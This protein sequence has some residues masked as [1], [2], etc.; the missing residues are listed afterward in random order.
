MVIAFWKSTLQLKAITFCG[1]IRCVHSNSHTHYVTY[2]ICWPYVS[3]HYI[4][5]KYSSFSPISLFFNLH[6]PLKCLLFVCFVL[7]GRIAIKTVVCW[8]G[9]ENDRKGI[10]ECSRM[11]TA[12][13]C[14]STWRIRMH[15]KTIS[16]PVKVYLLSNWRVVWNT[17]FVSCYGRLEQRGAPI[18][19]IC[20]R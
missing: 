15:S 2:G 4:T 9:A 6:S 17:A 7:F 20:Y 1:N 3:K 16:P 12:S 10:T 19:H 14:L 13:Y 5:E 11:W 18:S 8:N